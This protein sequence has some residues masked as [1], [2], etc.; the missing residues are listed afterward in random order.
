MSM[1]EGMIRV[2]GGTFHM[3]SDAHYQEERPAH[4]VHVD[5][6]WIDE[7]PVTNARFRAFVEAT[8]H[9]TAAEIVPTIPARGPRCSTRAP[10]SSS[11]RPHQWIAA[12]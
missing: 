4:A 7:Q 12:T 1:P 11:G 8:G 9:V 2:P 5:G 10:S 6:F 3:G